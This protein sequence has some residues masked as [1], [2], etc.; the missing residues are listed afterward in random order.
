MA[1]TSTSPSLQ[2]PQRRQSAAVGPLPVAA[3][4]SQSLA[5]AGSRAVIGGSYGADT[6][7]ASG[8]AGSQSPRL[9]PLVRLLSPI[10]NVTETATIAATSSGGR[11]HNLKEISPESA[12]S[13]ANTTRKSTGVTWA[14]ATAMNNTGPGRLQAGDLQAPRTATHWQAGTDTGC[15]GRITGPNRSRLGPESRSQLEG[16]IA[17]TPVSCARALTLPLPAIEGCSLKTLTHRVPPSRAPGDELEVELGPTRRLQM[18]TNGSAKTA[19][20]VQLETGLPVSVSLLNLKNPP[21]SPPAASVKLISAPANVSHRNATCD[22]D[23]PYH[24][25][26]ESRLGS[27]GHGLAKVGSGP[28]SCLLHGV[29]S[30]AGGCQETALVTS[31]RFP[32]D[33]CVGQFSMLRSQLAPATGQC[34]DDP[35]RDVVMPLPLAMIATLPT[36]MTTT[37]PAPI[38]GSIQLGVA[39]TGTG[40]GT[41]SAAG[42]I[43]TMTQGTMT[44][45]IQVEVRV[46]ESRN[47]SASG[48]TGTGSPRRTSIHSREI[49]TRYVP[50]R[51]LARVTASGVCHWQ[52]S[53]CSSL[54]SEFTPPSLTWIRGGPGYSRQ[55]HDLV[56][57]SDCR[58][59]DYD[60]GL[61]RVVMLVVS[62]GYYEFGAV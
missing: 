36:R 11:D 46:G 12:M 17:M 26:D 38:S 58:H 22:S 25:S 44:S 15:H 4:G 34:H 55:W 57:K 33:V 47:T 32:S 62:L 43:T 30:D 45:P 37:I 24:A 59:A 41:G 53:S 6:A 49:E 8:S 10:A 18:A 23:G 3:S 7:S 28:A 51:R 16:G 40:T 1:S 35:G 39:V 56:T 48:A 50:N 27:D 29:D 20:A 61:H 54:L 52:C 60:T 9:L 14:S 21:P 5:L 42:S 31:V 19:L 2:L 13:S